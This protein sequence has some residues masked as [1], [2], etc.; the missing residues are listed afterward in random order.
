MIRS[1]YRNTRPEVS[2]GT[3]SRPWVLRK[4][5]EHGLGTYQAPS[6]DGGR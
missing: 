1:V 3:G 2:T 6:V 5:L 4:V